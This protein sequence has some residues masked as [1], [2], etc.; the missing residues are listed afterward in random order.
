MHLLNAYS[1]TLPYIGKQMRINHVYV[2]L[3]C[4][5]IFGA[6]AAETF[7]TLVKILYDLMN[8]CHPNKF[9]YKITNV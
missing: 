5:K 6:F 1:L 7:S 2:L 9:N 3:T 8:Q 4:L